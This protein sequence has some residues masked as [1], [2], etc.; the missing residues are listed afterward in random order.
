MLSQIIMLTEN[1]TEE[2][3]SEVLHRV[4]S[5]FKELANFVNETD[6]IINTTVSWNDIEYL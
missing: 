2:Q 1:D 4:T 5:Y 6:V 3:T